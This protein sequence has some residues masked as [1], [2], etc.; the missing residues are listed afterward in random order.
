MKLAVVSS[1]FAIA[2]GVLIWRGVV[3]AGIRQLDVRE[4]RTGKYTSG[5]HV[6]VRGKIAK[7]ESKLPLR[8]T[9][10]AFRSP[11]TIEVA[12]Q[13]VHP[14]NFEVDNNCMVSGQFD[15]E[16][17]VFTAYR[18]VTECP[19]RYNAAEQLKRKQGYGDEGAGAKIPESLL[20]LNRPVSPFTVPA[21]APVAPRS[22]N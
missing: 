9:L 16:T 13:R 18:V 15:A 6:T 19:S 12:S 17:G 21:P 22:A 8:F 10:A 1:V 4:L 5:E 14:E 20:D 7:I 3:E 11:D 2:I